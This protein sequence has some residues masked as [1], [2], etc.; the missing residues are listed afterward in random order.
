[1]IYLSFLIYPYAVHWPVPHSL[2]KSPYQW[3]YTDGPHND[4][5]FLTIQHNVYPYLNNLQQSLSNV[6]APISRFAL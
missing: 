1:M 5:L 3:A 4:K 2:I 6:Q